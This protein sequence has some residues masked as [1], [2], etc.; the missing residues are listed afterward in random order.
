MFSRFSSYYELVNEPILLFND[1]E[2]EKIY[3]G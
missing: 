1:I 2:N 3:F